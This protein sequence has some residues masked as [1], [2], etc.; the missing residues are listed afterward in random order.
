M[1]FTIQP[2][3]EESITIH[4]DYD[5]IEQAIFELSNEGDDILVYQSYVVNGLQQQRLKASY[6]KNVF[7]IMLKQF[8]PELYEKYKL[9]LT[10]YEIA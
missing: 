1:Y 5:D 6:R 9:L 7:V 8:E 4:F 10:E 3:K 2:T